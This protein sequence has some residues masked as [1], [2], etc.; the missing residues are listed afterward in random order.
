MQ[1]QTSTTVDGGVTFVTVRAHNSA[2]N[3]VRFQVA[4]TLDGPV[5]PPRRHGHVERGWTGEEYEGVLAPGSSCWFG[6]ATPAE[7]D[8]EVVTLTVQDPI[9][10]SIDE[11]DSS[12][13]RETAEI[14]RAF[15]DPR[16]PR[17]VL[18]PI[19]DPSRAQS[20]GFPGGIDAAP[21]RTDEYR[22]GNQG[23]SSMEHG[24]GR[25]Q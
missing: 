22:A 13:Y 19:V 3:P 5:W 20:D 17:A 10:E 16:P 4:S 7:P 25:G 14:I 9:A 12:G 11:S 23:S 15:S 21:G 18:S 1:L 2:A 6:F 8:D 24:R